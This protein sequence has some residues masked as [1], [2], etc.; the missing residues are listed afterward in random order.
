[1]FQRKIYIILFCLVLAGTVFSQVKVVK[2]SSFELSDELKSKASDLLKGLARESDQF[3]L[4]E[5]RIVAR[6]QIANL[7]WDAD[8][9]QARQLFQSSITE[10]DTMIGALI[11]DDVVDD[12]RYIR[13]YEIGE[14][15]RELLFKIAKRDSA[16]AL[17]AFQTLSPKRP[18]GEDFFDGDKE[19]E[20]E[21][22]KN[23]ARNDPKKAYEVA[24]NQIAKGLPYGIVDTLENIHKK[25]DELGGKLA[26]SIL[27]LIKGQNPIPIVKSKSGSNSNSAAKPSATPDFP[28]GQDEITYWQVKEFAQKVKTLNRSSLKD[29]KSPALAENEYKELI[30]V[31]ARKFSSQSYTSAYDVAEFM[32]EIET[33]FPVLGQSIRKKLLTEKASLD[34]TILENALVIEMEDKSAKEIIEIIETKPAP[35]RDALYLKAAETLLDAGDVISAKELHQKAQVKPEYDY[36]A[37]RI[38]MELPKALATEGNSEEVRQFLNTA[39]TA[40]EK[41]EVL[42]TLAQS[43]AL[44]GDVKLARELTEEARASYL[45]KMKSYKNLGSIMHLAGAYALLVPEQSFAFIETNMSIINNIIAAGIVV[46]EF[47]DFGSVKDNEI[48]L[49]VIQTESYQNM[50]KG[51]LLL[52]NLSKADFERT[53]SVADQFA[54]REAKFFARFRIVQALLDPDAEEIEAQ[55]QITYEGEGC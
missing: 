6:T 4:P 20:L 22:A 46:D 2:K 13:I 38:K 33:Y 41:I 54:R 26:Q 17:S 10:L 16:Y 39:K 36:I 44:K 5:N 31:L 23:I 30:G 19:L 45:G 42:T 24:I 14:L 27:N 12:E 51:V 43:L 11:A 37:D 53:V 1:M 15:R 18:T 7:L 9:K 8:E 50:P 21:L 48:M 47:N 29:K 32:K 55:N 25:D 3:Y 52:R 34:Q 28:D 35:Q 49:N 40:E